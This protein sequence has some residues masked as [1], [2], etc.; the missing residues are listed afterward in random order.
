ME[1]RWRLMGLAAVLSFTLMGC[2]PAADFYAADASQA[3]QQQATGYRWVDLQGR[4]VVVNYFA[5]W[6]APCLKEVPEL[7]EFYHQHGAQV[8]LFAVSFDPLSNADLAGLQQ[9]YAMAFPLVQ[10]TPVAQLPFARPKMLPATY[11]VQP[12]GSIVGPLLG[13]QTLQSLRAVT[14]LTE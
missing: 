1:S 6:C 14:G 2:Q 5:E 8:P 4:Y 7:N 3:A 11:I 13:E 9:K 12:D 10:T